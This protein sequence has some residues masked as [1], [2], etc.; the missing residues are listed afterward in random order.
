[1]CSEHSRKAHISKAWLRNWANGWGPD[2]AVNPQWRGAH[3]GVARPGTSSIYLTLWHLWLALSRTNPSSLCAFRVC[4]S[5][6]PRISQAHI[7]GVNDPRA[8]GTYI[9]FIH[10]WFACPRCQSSAR[11]WLRQGRTLE[12]S[13]SGTWHWLDKWWICFLFL[14]F[15]VLL[16]VFQMTPIPLTLPSLLSISNEWDT[17]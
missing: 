12:F 1:M 17:T 2:A 7:S 10:Q 3:A 4:M 14:V 9:C 13:L 5:L 15:F 6:R 16:I 11:M 8:S